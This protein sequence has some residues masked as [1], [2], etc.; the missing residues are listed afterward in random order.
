MGKMVD[1]LQDDD[2]FGIDLDEA[3]KAR[4]E[5]FKSKGIDIEAEAKK[6]KG[7]PS[8]L[9]TIGDA[10]VQTGRGALKFYTWPLDVLKMG[11]I[12][13]GLSDMDE[14]EESFRK[15]DKPFNKEE[16][17]K[18]VFDMAQYVPTQE[19]AE[20]GFEGVTGLS[21]EPKTE[22]GEGIKQ[23]AE[24]ASFT[25]GGA[26]KKLGS[27]AIGS[28]TTQ[29]LK[30]A[31]VGDTKAEL[32][33]DAASL[34]PAFLEKS[35]K[36]VA[37]GAQ[38]LQSTAQKHS[39]PF[40]DYMVKERAPFL[41]GR[42][43]KNTE[44]RLKEE[45]NVSSTEAMKRIVEGE[46][47]IKRMRDRGVNLDSLAEH[48]YDVTRQL[49]Q[50]KPQVIKTDGIIK[51][52]DNEINRIKSLAPSPSDS[53]KSAIK[54]LE[55]ERDI[56]KVSNPSSEQLINQHINYNADMKQIYRKPEFSGKEEQVRK[57]YEFL[58]N[59]L[60][61][62]MEKQGSADVSN[63]FKAANK[64]YHEK[65][66]LTQTESLLGKA[67][68]GDSYNPK[69]LEKLLSSKQG[70]FLKRNMSESA[71]KELEEIAKYGVEAEGKMANF[72]D[73]RSPAIANE[74]KSWGQLA[75]MVFLPHNLNGAML[76]IA[77]PVAKHIQGKLLTR[78]ATREIYKLTLK[79]A[80]EG[81]FNL[82]KKDF[83]NLEREIVK[84]WGTVDDFMDDM[85]E[86]LEID[87][88]F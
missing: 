31:G 83:A 66:K 44:Q 63:A 26:V 15:A 81:S 78:P 8:W 10:F 34:S 70:N 5:G 46:L 67:F 25:R 3:V 45:F 40:L 75:P 53:Q 36:N 22:I 79:H 9:D 1:E 64:I 49:A 74:V 2:S 61:D 47:P 32:I 84:E 38:S 30:L 73:L 21:L 71:I 43:L 77:R 80:A 76:A 6:P 11:V 27:A 19:M 52:I 60:M 17:V 58:K 23:F 68:N 39:L 7:E 56:L 12:G 50:S 62:A 33:G 51:N 4:D 18:S 65:S 59:E 87:G 20:K 37:K 82:I 85:F 16:Y 14:L 86:G 54:L 55:D 24:I 13:E 72:I 57:T 29:G 28:G 41:K 69:K 35:A 88:E 48:S 42:L